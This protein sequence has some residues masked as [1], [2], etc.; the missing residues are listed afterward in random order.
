MSLQH[1]TVPWTGR[2]V[3]QFPRPD[4]GQLCIPGIIKEEA[5][6]LPSHPHAR[7]NRAANHFSQVV[8]PQAAL[9]LIHAANAVDGQIFDFNLLNDI[10]RRRTGF[11]LTPAFQIFL[12]PALHLHFFLSQM[13]LNPS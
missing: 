12:F 2:D 11:S 4:E 9:R 3:Q 10:R 8:T 13:R 5:E 1:P 6:A 7:R